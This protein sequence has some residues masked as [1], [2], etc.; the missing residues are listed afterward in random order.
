MN[1]TAKRPF[2]YDSKYFGNGAGEANKRSFISSISK[3]R[4]LYISLEMLLIY[5]CDRFVKGGN[6]NTQENW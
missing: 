3:A 1:K 4:E 2:Q 5:T 6:M